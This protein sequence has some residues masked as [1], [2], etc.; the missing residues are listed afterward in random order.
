MVHLRAAHFTSGS[1]IGRDRVGGV[2][3]HGA[4]EGAEGESVG[5][6]DDGRVVS[7]FSRRYLWTTCDIV[8]E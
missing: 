1:E 8:S 4:E 3:W 6:T 7:L 5:K 2:L